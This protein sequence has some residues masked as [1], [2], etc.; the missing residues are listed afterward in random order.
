MLT[1]ILRQLLISA[2]TLLTVNGCLSVFYG[3]DGQLATVFVEAE[4]AEED[5]RED[6]ITRVLDPIGEAE[7]QT[8][9]LSDASTFVEA[10]VVC[11]PHHER[12][13]P[14]L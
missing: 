6:S 13:P 7:L 10:P 2:A 4:D 11:G 9:I 5:Q 8:S 1:P 14:I 3:T 12:G